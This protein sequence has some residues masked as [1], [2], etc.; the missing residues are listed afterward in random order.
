MRPVQ[1][2][3]QDPGPGVPPIPPLEEGQRLD[4]DEFLR[5]Y[6]AMPHLTGAELIEGVVRM[7]SPVRLIGHGEE[8]AYLVGWMV[9]YK[10]LTP[11]TRAGD[12][13]TTR[14]DLGNVPQ[15]DV[16]LLIDPRHGG[17]VRIDEKGYVVGAAELVAEVSGTRTERDLVERLAIY[18]RNGVREYIVWRIEDRQIDWFVLRDGRFVPLTPGPDGVRRSEVFPGLWLDGAA[19][20]AGDLGRTFA[21][22]QQGLASPEHAAFVARLAQ[23][24]AP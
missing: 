12:N 9:N 7:P 21:V 3:P 8:H 17:K 13:T 24:V 6:E 2:P 10:V 11:G 19:L 20:V 1:T 4:A 5:R 16:C 14:L 18:Q 15:P 22:L 23:A